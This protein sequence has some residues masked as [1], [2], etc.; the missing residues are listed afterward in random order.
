MTLLDVQPRCAA[1]AAAL[2][3]AAFERDGALPRTLRTVVLF[4]GAVRR[5]PFLSGIDRSPL[6]LPVDAGRTVGD[7]WAERSKQPM[8]L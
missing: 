1:P 5:S 6:D 4:D 7:V 3:P 2:V 8:L